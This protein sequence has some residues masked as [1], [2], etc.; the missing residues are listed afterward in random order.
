QSADPKRSITSGWI[1]RSANELQDKK[2]NVP[3]MQIGASK[4]PL[5]L[6]GGPGGV[7]SIN[8]TQPYKLDLGTTDAAKKKVRRQLMEDLAKPAEEAGKEDLLQFVRKRQLQTYTT[9]DK[10]QEVLQTQNPNGGI[11]V[12]GSGQFYQPGSLVHKMT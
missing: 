6:Q 12:Q 11:F 7:V 10:I 9:V 5:A 2:G 4:L 8:N 1:G 3:I